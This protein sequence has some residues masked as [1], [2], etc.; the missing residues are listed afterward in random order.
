MKIRPVAC[1][2]LLSLLGAVAQ[3]EDLKIADLPES[4]PVDTK[5]RLA[6]GQVIKYGSK[7]MFAP[8]RDRSF[9]QL[10]D[11]S[12]DGQVTRAL[13]ML[14]L[15]AGQ[16][17][18]VEL[19]GF[20]EGTALKA[21][22]VNFAQTDG[23]C[24]LPGGQD[25]AWRASGNEPGWILAA[26]GERMQLKRNGKPEVVLPYAPFKNENGVA[27]Y[28]AVQDNQK[29]GLRFEHRLCRDALAKSVFGWTATV[30]LDGEVLQGCAWQR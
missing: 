19:L 7:V 1:V 22:Q 4:K 12:D 3:A 21:S 11:V 29:L 17:L 13:D 14:G 6:Y 10:E 9:T 27:T 5:P 15:S 26:G 23:R 18:Y 28:E 20:V 2:I 30:T 24:R 25:E 16:K 8:C